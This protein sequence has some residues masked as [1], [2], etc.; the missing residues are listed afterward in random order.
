MYRRQVRASA[1]ASPRAIATIEPLLT[2]TRD[3]RREL[4]HG[5]PGLVVAQAAV[6]PQSLALR[7]MMADRLVEIRN[8]AHWRLGR[9]VG[10]TAGAYARAPA[11]VA[12][13]AGVMGVWLLRE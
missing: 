12:A 2:H 11:G 6:K 4:I 7:A 1:T 5:V 10:S 13:S 8:H 3:W 9:V